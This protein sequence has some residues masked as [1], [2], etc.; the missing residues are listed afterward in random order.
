MISIDD[1]AAFCKRKGF[2]YPSSEIYGGLAGMYDYG[3]YGAQMKRNLMAS[4]WRKHVE[5]RDDVVGID[6]SIIS[7]QKVWEASGHLEG[8]NDPVLI[9]SKCKKKLRA[10][11]FIEEKSGLACDGKTVGELNALVLEYGLACPACKGSF[12]EITSFNIMFPVSVGAGEGSSHV[13]YLR[14]ETA[15][16]IFTNFKLV[17][18][19]ARMQVPFGIAQMGKAFRNEISPRNFLFRL[20]EFEQMEIE[21]FVHPN[22]VNDCPFFA[23]VANHLVHV[24]SSDMQL[25]GKQAELM[26][27][28]QAVDKGLITT[29]WHAYWLAYEHQWFVDLGAPAE[30]FRIRQHLPTEKSH[31]A[32]DTWDLEY[33]FPF[34]WK[35]LQ[36]LA[37]R[38]DYDL[39]RHGEYSGKAIMLFDSETNKKFVPYVVAEPSQ[40]VDRAFLVFMYAAYDDD[41]GRGNIVLHLHPD[42]APVQV[43]VFP[44]VKKMRMLFT[45]S[46]SKSSDVRL[47]CPALLAVG[48]PVLM[49]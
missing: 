37:N 19:N 47:M 18:E 25:N 39:R 44:L 20:R 38:T 24:Y 29:I 46:C 26:T 15:Q 36:G 28:Q 14:G 41:K 16:M 8:L 7:P 43:G 34:G 42:L 48:M 31:Y 5:L 13:A 17:A 35:E 27:M 33:G 9:C 6:A 1:M 45:K 30:K 21:Y 3:P 2:V 32:L 22:K 11:T 4:W 12:S 10:D 40:G 23:D 49:S